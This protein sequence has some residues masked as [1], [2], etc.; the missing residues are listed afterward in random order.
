MAGLGPQD[1]GYLLKN[2]NESELAELA[3]T[4]IE[5]NLDLDFRPVEGTNG[6]TKRI[7]NHTSP[8][9]GLHWDR[10]E[11]NFDPDLLVSTK[12]QSD[13]H[14]SSG[15]QRMFWDLLLTSGM[16]AS[17]GRINPSDH[18]ITIVSPWITDVPYSGS[19]GPRTVEAD[20]LH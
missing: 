3:G 5:P 4:P 8:I 9:I 13:A 12:R 14:L 15:H 11:E 7:V 16:W 20:P 18:T 19:G 6:M 2:S 10:N 1:D 17:S